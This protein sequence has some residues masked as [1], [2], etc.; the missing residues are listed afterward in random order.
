MLFTFTKDGQRYF[1]QDSYQAKNE[2]KPQSGNS[3]EDQHIKIAAPAKS[4]QP[5]N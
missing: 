4:K 1:Q 3:T 2:K 5:N